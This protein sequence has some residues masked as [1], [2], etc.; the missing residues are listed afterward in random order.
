MVTP[1]RR[2]ESSTSATRSPRETPPWCIVISDA[3]IPEIITNAF[4]NAASL[5]ERAEQFGANTQA[6]TDGIGYF[7]WRH[8]DRSGLQRP[9]PSPAER[10]LASRPSLRLS[11]S[12]RLLGPAGPA[13]GD[14]ILGPPR[15]R[16]YFT[17]STASGASPLLLF[18]PRR[19]TSI[20]AAWQPSNHHVSPTAF[21]IASSNA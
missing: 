5:F 1:S 10:L 19:T 12:W 21:L 20:S 16:R 13:F 4:R 6:L 14:P 17:S 2:A 9:S 11:S 18:R 3:T 8:C 15:S 7:Y